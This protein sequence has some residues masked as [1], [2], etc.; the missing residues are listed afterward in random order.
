MALSI[1]YH[2]PA[3]LNDYY[4]EGP[5]SASQFYSKNCASEGYCSESEA[6]LCENF[7]ENYCVYQYLGF[8]K[9]S[10]IDGEHWPPIFK[11]KNVRSVKE[12]KPRNDDVFVC[13]YPKCGTTWI[14]HICAQLMTKNY[15]PEGGNELSI[16]SPMIDRMGAE[17]A[18]QLNSPRLLKTHFTW[19]NLPKSSKAKYIYC[20]RNPKD[21]LTS[22]YFHN[23]NF[24]IYNYEFGTFDNFFEWFMSDKIA[25]GNYYWHLLS[26]LPHIND[27]N[28]L[29]LRYED[30]WA[31]LRTA[32]KKIGHFL[33]GKAAEIVDDNKQLERVVNESKIDSMKKDQSRWFPADNLRGK[34]FIRKG[35]SRDW[36]NYFSK[37]QSDRMDKEWQMQV[38][39]TVAENWWKAEM[40]WEEIEPDD[41]IQDDFYSSGPFTNAPDIAFTAEE[42]DLIRECSQSIGIS[43]CRKHLPSISEESGIGSYDD[44]YLK[45]W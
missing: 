12:M 20:V 16:T 7:A 31:D 1:T 14:Q 21:C 45:P 36:K 25:F 43:S 27:E 18:D 3:P 22:Y 9:Q 2:H 32:V 11:P 8:P 23:Q 17:Y 24:K 26:W 29:F 41:G 33:G 28:V 6:C 19:N 40:S 38:A 42:L 13:T 39:G 35:G 4:G 34:P 30:M 10:F 5:S 44:K 15:E 37:E